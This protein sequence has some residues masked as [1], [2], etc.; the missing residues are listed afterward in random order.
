M[1]TEARTNTD[2]AAQDPRAGRTARRP[3]RGA[4]EVGTVLML[5]NAVLIGV[6]ST[7]LTSGSLGV[8]A[9]TVTTAFLTILVYLRVGRPAAS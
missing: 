6:P 1:F 8:T 4:D 2:P 5:M 9:L 3:R 7:Y